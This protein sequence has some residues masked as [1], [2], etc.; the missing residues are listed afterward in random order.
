[1]VMNI[2]ESNLT[3]TMIRSNLVNIPQ[4]PLPEGITMRWYEGADAGLWVEIQTQAEQRLPI[5]KELFVKEFGEDPSILEQRQCFL[6]DA[7]G[8]GV[9]TAT[10]WFDHNY[11]GAYYGRIHWVAVVPD[12]QSKGLGKALLT[13]MCNRLHSLGHVRVYLTTSTERV[14]AIRLYHRFGF[15][16]EIRNARDQAIWDELHAN[17]L[18]AA[19]G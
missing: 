15:G 4:F 14:A 7:S 2:V 18:H 12:M 9:G 13:I 3:I 11:N 16:P 10:A 19:R 17:V 8:R 5:S 1:M 6:I